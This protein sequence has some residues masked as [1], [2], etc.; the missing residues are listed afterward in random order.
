MRKHCI[1]FLIFILNCALGPFAAAQAF[2]PESAKTDAANQKTVPV[3][4]VVTVG[5]RHGT[6]VPTLYRE[7]VRV[8]QEDRRVKV[9]DWQP[10]SAERGGLQLFILVDDACDTSAGSQLDELR[11][12]VEAQSPSTLVGVGFIRN[13]SVLIA[14]NLT[15][16]HAL[17]AHALRIPLGFFAAYSSPYLA[18][19]S[20]VEGWPASRD[21]RVI[22]LMSPGIDGLQPGS[23]NSYLQEA[24]Q[25][26]RRANI[27]VY[28]IYASPSGRFGRNLWGVNFGQSNLAQLA[29]ETGGDAYFQGFET[30]I[31][32]APFLEQF[33]DRLGHQYSLTFLANAGDEPKD[34]RIR[35][36]TEVTNAELAGPIMVRIPAAK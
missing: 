36:E 10:L 34:Y 17:A 22:F 33:V 9:M 19:T 30:P 2:R 25:H 28:T 5:A 35:L 16:D 7:D 4:I 11:T 13:S 18:I 32:F 26:A 20:L 15:P 8:Y 1:A 29:D 21:R 23:S 27:E 14:Q 6:R 31:S 24:I 12:F 3:T